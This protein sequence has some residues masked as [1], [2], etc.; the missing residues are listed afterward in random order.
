MPIL[1]KTLR[2]ALVP[3]KDEIRLEVCAVGEPAPTYVWLKNGEEIYLSP[4]NDNVSISNEGFV[5]KLTIHRM[6]EQD[7]VRKNLTG[8]HTNCESNLCHFTFS[9]PSSSRA[10]T[11]AK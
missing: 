3:K 1:T 4:D 11:H 5:S 6:G 7:Q 10:C 8:E 2:D 9:F